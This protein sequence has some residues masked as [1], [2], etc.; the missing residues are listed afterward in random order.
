L[1]DIK[2]GTVYLIPM[3]LHE[4]ALH[5]LPHEVVEAVKKCEVFFVENERT[6]RR[7]MKKIWKEIVIDNYKWIPIHKAEASVKNQLSQQLRLH[8]QIGILSEAGC[9][10][11]ADPGQLLV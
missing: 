7:F 10:G 2:K 11:I 5:T 8:K 3:P 1:G 6:A 4:D 9:P